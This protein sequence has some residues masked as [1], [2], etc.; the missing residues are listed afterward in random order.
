M[1]N[2]MSLLIDLHESLEEFSKI[3][4]S[5]RA[6]DK[7]R[8]WEEFTLTEEELSALQSTE[9]S[10]KSISAI[11]KIVRDRMLLSFHHFLAVLDGV[12][13][14]RFRKDDSVW[15]GL[16]LENK[17]ISDEAG[18]EEFLHDMLFEAYWKWLEIKNNK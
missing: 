18:D 15:L 9:F 12:G 5:L 3:G 17:S 2:Q 11:E 10:G 7:A 4:D 8:V 6:P 1:D 16:R 14:P 13:D